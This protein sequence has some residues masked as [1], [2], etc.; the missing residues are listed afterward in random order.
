MQA[1]KDSHR[2]YSASARLQ[3][4]HVEAFPRIDGGDQR[5]GARGSSEGFRGGRKGRL[6]MARKRFDT[7]SL[8]RGLLSI[9]VFLILWE[10]GSRSKPRLG[11]DFLAAG[12]RAVRGRGSQKK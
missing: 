3:R 9:V 12:R 4:A 8:A 10:I 6:A 1:K 7:R 5:S 11:G 2:R